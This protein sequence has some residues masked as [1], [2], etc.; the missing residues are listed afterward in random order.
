MP[1]LQ[2]ITSRAINSKEKSPHPSLCPH[3]PNSPCARQG[4]P[5]PASGLLSQD[6]AADAGWKKS[7]G[8]RVLSVC[9]MNQGW[10]SWQLLSGLPLKISRDV[11]PPARQTPPAPALPNALCS[12]PCLSPSLVMIALTPHNHLFLIGKPFLCLTFFCLFLNKPNSFH[13]CSYRSF[14]PAL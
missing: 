2:N 8:Q 12:V 9:A 10:P 13:F 5:A 4:I 3:T 6:G 11:A 14:L 7:H 1:K